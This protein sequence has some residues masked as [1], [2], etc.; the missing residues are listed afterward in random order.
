MPRYHLF[1]ASVTIAQLMEQ[2]GEPE[3]VNAS[4]AFCDK[5]D[6]RFFE[7]TP[8]EPLETQEFGAVGMS[9]VNSSYDVNDLRAM[10]ITTID[11]AWAH[12]SFNTGSQTTMMHTP[13]MRLSA[14][15][16][17]FLGTP[18]MRSGQM[19]PVLFT[20]SQEFGGDRAAFLGQSSP[21]DKFVGDDVKQQQTSAVARGV[22]EN[23]VDDMTWPT[24]SSPRQTIPLGPLTPS[25]T[26]AQPSGEQPS[27]DRWE[28]A[29]P[30]S[31][32]RWEVMTPPSNTWHIAQETWNF[33]PV[34]DGTWNVSAPNTWDMTPAAQ[35]STPMHNQYS[36]T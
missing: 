19:P 11:P 28:V 9:F 5:L 29:T 31:I 25:P 18:R 34:V 30:P 1:G 3:R 13:S 16:T 21:A 36:W 33:S 23:N 15:L 17:S 14:D 4:N 24:I 2:N 6:R 7:I 8:R 27:G 20:P 35:A 32:N 22:E 26:G 12:K 10:L